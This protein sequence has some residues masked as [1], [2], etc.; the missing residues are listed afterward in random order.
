M[1]EDKKMWEDY[2]NSMPSFMRPT[3]AYIAMFYTKSSPPKTKHVR[4]ISPDS[5]LLKPTKAS[6]AWAKKEEQVKKPAVKPI[7]PSSSLLRE[8]KALKAYKEQPCE[9]KRKRIKE[10][11]LTSNLLKT[12]K[13]LTSYQKSVPCKH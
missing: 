9:K 11:P 6:Q 5:H 3:K 12:T 2:I 4:R 10:I 13:A 7:S 8:T 1:L